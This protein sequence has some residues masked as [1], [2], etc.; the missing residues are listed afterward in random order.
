MANLKSDVLNNLKVILGKMDHLFPK[1]QRSKQ[2]DTLLSAADESCKE[3][4]VDIHRL[5]HE[6]ENEANGNTKEESYPRE[7]RRHHNTISGI[8]GG[9]LTAGGLFGIS[10]LLGGSNISAWSNFLVLINTGIGAVVGAAVATPIKFA[11]KARFD[12]K[13]PK[14]FMEKRIMK[15]LNKR[16]MNATAL[17][18]EIGLYVDEIVQGKYNFKENITINKKRFNLK[19]QSRIVTREVTQFKQ[20]FKTLSRPTQRRLGKVINSINNNYDDLTQASCAALNQGI[21]DFSFDYEQKSKEILDQSI[22]TIVEQIKNL[23]IIL[24][25]P[26]VTQ[27]QIK[28]GVEAITTLCNSLKTDMNSLSEVSSVLKS[29]I[30]LGDSLNSNIV[31]S[32]AK[33]LSD[34]AVDKAKQTTAKLDPIVIRDC[35][36]VINSANTVISK[37]ND[38]LTKIREENKLK[39][40]AKKVV[41]QNEETNNKKVKEIQDD[42]DQLTILKVR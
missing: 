3:L 32:D 9:L 37:A 38:K 27:T 19:G 22:P 39:R 6:F 2:I 29:L 40:A 26:S 11:N 42:I 33:S 1:N 35:T 28:D 14:G 15:K 12:S 20:K 17:D 41:L 16:K 34:K 18:S 21:L 25:S 23:E 7:I 36:A 30:T 4:E 13:H 8:I 24:S 10:Y 31:E 5:K